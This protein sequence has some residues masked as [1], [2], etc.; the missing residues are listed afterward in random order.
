MLRVVWV[1]K[2]ILIFFYAWHVLKAWC[3]HAMEKI[4]D[5]EVQRII[6]CDL[7]DMMYMSN[8]PKENIKSFK[9]RKKMKV[10]Q[11]FEQHNPSD[12]WTLLLDLLLSIWYVFIFNFYC[13]PSLGLATKVRARKVAS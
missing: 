8:K 6:L 5:V 4:K 10:L 7:H 12:S 2:N 3:L 13:N 1:I 9:K 11:S